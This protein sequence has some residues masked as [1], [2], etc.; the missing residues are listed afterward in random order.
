MIF[1]EV[2]RVLKKTG[3]FFLNL[4]DTYVGGHQGGSI[5]GEITGDRYEDKSMIPQ[6]SEG[7]RPQSKVE[8]WKQKCLLCMPER[9]MFSCIS[10]GFI[11][12]NKIPWIKDNPMPSSVTDRFN[13]TWEYLYFFSKTNKTQYWVNKKTAQLVSKQPKGIKGEEGKDWE[14]RDCPNCNGI[15][16]ETKIPKEQA[17]TFIS[18]RG[19]YHRGNKDEV[20]SRCKG[21]GRIKRS[22]WRGHDYF[23]DIDS[24]RVP[25]KTDTLA[26]YG[27]NYGSPT[28]KY[29]GQDTTII[30]GAKIDLRPK[31]FKKD[32]SGDPFGKEG[33]DWEW[34]QGEMEGIDPFT[35]EWVLFKGKIPHKLKHKGKEGMRPVSPPQG[36]TD[37]HKGIWGLTSFERKKYK[38]RENEIT[39]TSAAKLAKFRDE[40]RKKTAD[41]SFKAGS[42]RQSPE[43][44]EEGAFNTKGRGPRDVIQLPTSPFSKAHFAVFPSSLVFQPILASC[45]KEVCSK[46]GLP[47]VRLTE[48]VNKVCKQWGERKSKPWFEDKREMPQKK[49]YESI[50]ETTGYATCNCGEKFIPG[51]VLDPFIGAGTSALVSRILNKDFIGIDIKQEYCKMSEER[52]KDPAEIK[53]AVKNI[54]DNYPEIWQR[55]VEGQGELF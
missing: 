27:R 3:S 45:P 29:I 41:E 25:P 50:K 18:P 38:G 34:R 19:R 55:E 44:G 28:N 24:L 2:Y 46:C 33:V 10:M 54:K 52:I 1:K 31:E 39:F 36:T 20:C 21:T 26:R 47:K 8:G 14:W 32:D 23:F 6:W 4:G 42:M 11:L 53:R 43:P 13:T 9:I 49:I 40:A 17:E 16:G 5:H 51:I 15:T 22:F 7:G 48:I 12:R 35:G 37:Q 30:G